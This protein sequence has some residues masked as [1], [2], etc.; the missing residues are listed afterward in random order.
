MLGLFVGLFYA[1][2][3]GVAVLF[4]LA[5]ISPWIWAIPLLG[6]FIGGLVLIIARGDKIVVA[7]KG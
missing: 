7:E 4:M 5:R 1:L 2:V 3:L 6:I